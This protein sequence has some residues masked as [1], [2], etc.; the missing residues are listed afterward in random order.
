LTGYQDSG[1]DIAYNLRNACGIN[2]A[3]PHTSPDP[4]DQTHWCFPDTEAGILATLND[5]ATH[6]WANTI[7]YKTHALQVSSK[8]G[9]YDQDIKVIGQPPCL[10][11]LYDDKRYVNDWLRSTGQFSMPKAWTLTRSSL[12]NAAVQVAS[13][14]L[15][16]P[17]VAKPCR[18]RG[19]AGVK[20]CKT[21]AE[22]SQ[23]VESLYHDASIIMLEEFLEGEEATVTVM[24]PSGSR[25]DYWAMPVVTRFNHEDGIAPYN[26]NVAVTLNSRAVTTEA[27]A[28]DSTYVEVAR[29]CEGVARLLEMTAPIRI[30]VRRRR[31][32]SLSPFVLFDINMKPVSFGVPA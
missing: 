6:L 24:P 9:N 5:G 7:V 18:G 21:A 4:R 29:Q 14:D 27:V 20:L 31:D 30:D 19:S 26:G 25:G 8:I 23:H 3:T 11:E 15:E 16:Y 1:A 10:V 13:L 32:E 22:L 28:A 12:S 17:I 2:V